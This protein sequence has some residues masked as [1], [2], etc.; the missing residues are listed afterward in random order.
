MRF[1]VKVQWDVEAG[2]A[3]A[4]GGALGTTVASILE[5][6]KPEAAYFT[7]ENGK[8]T[9][10]LFMNLES[11]SQIP[12]I[13]EPWFLTVNAAIDFVPVMLP[14]DLKEAGPA[15]EQAVERYGG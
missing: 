9:G 11:A 14:E 3:L 8:R 1:L 15:I 13:A 10:L 12:A 5:E 4:R 6:Q 2:N 7:A